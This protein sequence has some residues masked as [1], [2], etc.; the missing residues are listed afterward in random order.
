MSEEKLMDKII[1][2]SLRRGFVNPT[3]E[4][5]GGVGGFFEYGP[6]GTLMKQKIIDLWRQIF[7]LDEDRVFCL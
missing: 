4:I 7:V 2:V 3:A 6:L 1:D 5:Y